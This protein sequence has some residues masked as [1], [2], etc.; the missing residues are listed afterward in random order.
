M[1][2]LVDEALSKLAAAPVPQEFW[3]RDAAIFSRLD[4]VARQRKG[5]GFRLGSV[6]AAAAI[7][8]GIVGARSI[9]S[10]VYSLNPL[11]PEARLA[12]SELLGT[13]L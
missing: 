5:P 12:P 9:G 10:P 1:S 3:S 8:M 2:D 4:S 6:A 7:L 11:A 13:Q